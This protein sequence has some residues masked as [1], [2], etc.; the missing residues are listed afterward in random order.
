ME[1]K[2]NGKHGIEGGVIGVDRRGK[3]DK[4]GE[5]DGRLGEV[6]GG[7]TEDRGSSVDRREKWGVFSPFLSLSSLC[8]LATHRGR[9]PSLS[10]CV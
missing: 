7:G 6:G 4:E 8:S 1:K 5:K 2:G 10:V 3:V 9:I